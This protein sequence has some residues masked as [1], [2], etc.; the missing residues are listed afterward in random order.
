MK[1]QLTSLYPAALT[2]V[3]QWYQRYRFCDAGHPFWGFYRQWKSQGLSLID[4]LMT[5]CYHS[6]PKIGYNAYGECLPRYTFEDSMVHKLLYQI[7]KPTFKSIISPA[8]H[9]LKGPSAI[10]PI[11]HQ[12]HNALSSKKYRYM[13]RTDVKSYYASI[14]I[15]LLKT[16]I[17][18]HFDDPRL[19][20]ILTGIIDA[21]IDRGGWFEHPHTGILVRS[22][23]STF[24]AALYLKPL[25][26]CFDQRADLFYCRY[27][28]DIV[29]LCKTKR[30]YTK[31]KRRLKD[32]FNTLTLSMAPK[33]TSMGSVNKGFHFL[34]IQFTVARTTVHSDK[35]E[36][37]QSSIKVSLHPRSI[38]R[39]ID[40]LK[41]KQ[42]EQR[43]L[44]H[45][46]YSSADHPAY[47]QS[48]CY[49]WATWWTSQHPAL[50]CTRTTAIAQWRCLWAK[51]SD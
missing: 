42:E 34:G 28:D 35:S 27:N 51:K 30:Q 18:N 12:I 49:R 3:Y 37:P 1:W 39:S 36:Q 4:D 21:P 23:L 45:K 29:I 13:I 38:R 8:C 48:H 14:D 24:F 6:S 10:K 43:L 19:V 25:D 44:E 11:T 50:G 9:H 46:R 41:L 17:K 26:R 2:L 20:K 16:M 32:T 31:A 15:N 7:I 5:G 22:A 40:K 47:V 33:K